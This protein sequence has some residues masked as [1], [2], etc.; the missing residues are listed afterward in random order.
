[1][2]GLFICAV[3]IGWVVATVWGVVGWYLWCAGL[4]EKRYIKLAFAVFTWAIDVTFFALFIS[5][6]YRLFMLP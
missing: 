3:F 2:T 4:S 6:M 1:M 5:A